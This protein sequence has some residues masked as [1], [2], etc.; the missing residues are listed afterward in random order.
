MRLFLYGTLQPQVGTPMGAWIAARLVGSEPAT[1]PGRLHAVRGGDGWFPAL[2]AGGGRS[3]HGSLC[4]LRL[5][6][7]DLAV[8]DRY[9]GREY[10]RLV[11]PVRT[12][13][14]RRIA[15]WTYVWRVGLP[16]SAPA[17]DG[18]DFLAWLRTG[19]RRAFCGT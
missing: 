2:M 11:V 9:E 19:R 12:V 8:L 7:D 4:T 16:A 17:I 13:A 5:T 15:A 3:V 18:G 1:V 10:R 6:A 14:G